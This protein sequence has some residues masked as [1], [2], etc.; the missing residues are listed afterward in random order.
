MDTAELF[1]AIRSLR[2]RRGLSLAE[3]ET[4][5]G[6]PKTRLSQ[7]ERGL[8]PDTSLAVVHRIVS[9]CGSTLCAL[10]REARKGQLASR[11]ERACD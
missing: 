7:I 4:G 3:V 6:I 5:C 9:A 11:F 1:S 8:R 2:E 10:E